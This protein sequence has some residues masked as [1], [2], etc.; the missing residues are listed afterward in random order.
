[1]QRGKLKIGFDLDGVIIDH[2]EIK[3]ET[4]KSLGYKLKKEESHSLKMK[5]KMEIEDYR[6]LQKIIYGEETLK[7]KPVKDSLESIGYLK[8]LGHS[9]FIISRRNSEFQS[10]A[11]EWLNRN[12]VLLDIPLVKIKFVKEDKDKNTEASK[13]GLSV[14]LDDSIDVLLCL[15]SVKEKFLLDPFMDYKKV[16]SYIHQISSWKEFMEKIL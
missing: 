14:F 15:N 9:L 4:A 16:P 2:T 10:F 5:D 11:L 12:K 7:S 6:K 1:M 13:L 3:L 8:N